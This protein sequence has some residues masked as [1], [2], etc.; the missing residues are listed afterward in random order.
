MKPVG[1][2]EPFIGKNNHL[3]INTLNKVLET[4]TVVHI[5]SITVP[6]HNQSEMVQQQ[7]AFVTHNPSLTGYLLPTDLL[8]SAPFSVRVNRFKTVSVNYTDA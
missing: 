4:T 5:G 6:I 8:P 2:G 1:F 3:L 7:T